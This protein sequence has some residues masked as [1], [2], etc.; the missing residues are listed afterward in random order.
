MF[1][2][3]DREEDRDSQRSDKK[4]LVGNGVYRRHV[5]PYRR[6]GPRRRPNRHYGR[7]TPHD[8]QN[9]RDLRSN[10]QTERQVAGAS[11][12][13]RRDLG[14]PHGPRWGCPTRE[15]TEKSAFVAHVTT[16]ATATNPHRST[17][18]SFNRQSTMPSEST[19][20]PYGETQSRFCA[21]LSGAGVAPSTNVGFQSGFK[22][23]G[24]RLP[25]CAMWVVPPRPL[26]PEPPR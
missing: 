21:R 14:S 25:T 12:G 15:S 8:S 24:L 19:Q 2:A 23:R 16:G 17:G 22:A 7:T 1:V 9:G 3:G 4:T 20:G 5:G 6:C 18:S 11:A 13:C 10:C 26:G